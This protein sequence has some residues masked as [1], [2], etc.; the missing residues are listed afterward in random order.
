MLDLHDRCLLAEK[1]LLKTLNPGADIAV[2]MTVIMPWTPFGSQCHHSP[3][4]P[5]HSP[6]DE[7]SVILTSC[8]SSRRQA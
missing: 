5:N 7:G 2:F 4:S 3:I 8:V 1:E 6:E